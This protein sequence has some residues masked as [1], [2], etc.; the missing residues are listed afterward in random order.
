MVVTGIIGAVAGA[1]ISIATDVAAGKDIN[2]GKAGGYAAAGLL[3]GLTLG[4]GT[5]TAATATAV[6]TGNAAASFSTVTGYGAATATAATTSALPLGSE[7]SKQYSNILSK[8]Q[9][10][11]VTKVAEIS[12]NF[13]VR[14]TLSGAN[15]DQGHIEKTKN[16]I[17]GLQKVL[18]SIQ[19]SLQNKN[20]SPEARTVLLTAQDEAIK[21]IQIST[22]LLEGIK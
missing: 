18:V 17:V 2:W 8:S 22:E 20:L 4:A 1:G 12:H 19:G 9:L 5:A 10:S 14:N 11:S 7:I 6:S 21:L 3:V 16:S 15:L 13:T